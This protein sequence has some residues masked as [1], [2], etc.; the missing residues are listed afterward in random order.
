MMIAS[1]YSRKVDLLL[2]FSWASIVVCCLA[3]DTLSID[4]PTLRLHFQGRKKRLLGNFHFADLLHSFFP[5]FLLFQ[6]LAF[7][8]YIAVV[9]LRCYVLPQW[10]LRFV[11]GHSLVDD[12]LNN[13]F[14]QLAVN[15][16]MH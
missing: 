12:G 1:A 8:R 15:K 9:A 10:F 3:F 7:A 14:E 4:I 13:H 5:F 11:P 6:E 16:L 2:T